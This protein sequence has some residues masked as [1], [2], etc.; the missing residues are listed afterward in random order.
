MMISFRAISVAYLL[1]LS[2]ISLQLPAQD[3]SQKIDKILNAKCLNQK[4]TAV[5]VVRVSDGAS[6]YQRRINT[7][8]LPASTQKIVTTAAALHYLSP[9]YRF[10]TELRRDGKQEGKVLQGNLILRGYGNPKLYTAGLWEIARRVYDGGIRE[11][12]GDLIAD[13]HFFDDYKRAPS[14]QKKRSQRPYDA[15]IGAL[16][17][18]YN[19][20]TVRLHPQAVGEKVK[21]WISPMPAHIRL[22]NSSK[23]VAK[24]KKQGVWA[25]RA[26]KPSADGK[27]EIYIKG[28][29]PKNAGEQ[30]LVM[31]VENPVRYTLAS[32][33]A[34]LEEMGIKI[35]G[36]N[37]ISHEKVIGNW[38][39]THLSPP[40]SVL[41]KELNTYS[42]NFMAEQIVKTIAATREKL[43]ATHVDAMVLI[44]DFLKEAGIDTRSLVLTDGSGL[45]RQ[46]RFT[47]KAMT[48][49]MGYMAGRFDIG[50]DFFTALRV[51]GARGAPSKRLRKSPAKGQIRGKTGTLSGVSTLVGYVAAENGE[52]YSYAFFLNSNRCG[53]RG[54]DNIEDAMIKAIYYNDSPSPEVSPLVES[55]GSVRNQI[56]VDTRISCE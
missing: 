8:L 41:L 33:R 11:I 7:P 51:M 50:P 56:S 24:G 10:K 5:H 49:L 27:L 13:V 48:D 6:I 36:K 43:P 12:N 17:L 52:L 14:W 26:D 35:R 25:S 55:L 44:E 23:T 19:T 54:A 53:Y 46:D 16:S 3:L 45:S 9:E 31:N 18:N 4:K 2:L 28:N 1:G 38:M 20:L 37:R 21:A 47:V 22:V 30:T 39:Y 15:N 42:N 40:L 32:F 29:M 34:L